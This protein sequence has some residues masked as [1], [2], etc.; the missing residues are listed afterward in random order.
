LS[1]FQKIGLKKQALA[2]EIKNFHHEKKKRKSPSNTSRS[3]LK[4][5]SNSQIKIQ[6]IEKK[7]VQPK[8]KI[9]IKEAPQKINIAKQNV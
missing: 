3:L 8:E 6:H 7:V 1:S 5:K 4:N 9:K 2:R